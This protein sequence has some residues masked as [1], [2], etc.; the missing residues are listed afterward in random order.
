LFCRNLWKRSRFAGNY[1]MKNRF[2]GGQ[3]SRNIYYVNRDL[4]N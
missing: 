3:S 2:I 4:Y 1:F